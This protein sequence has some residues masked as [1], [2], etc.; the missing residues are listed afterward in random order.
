MDH[1]HTAAAR[2]GKGPLGGSK[3]AR[4]R[5]YLILLDN[6]ELVRT[7]VGD[8]MDGWMDGLIGTGWDRMGSG[9]GMWVEIERA[10]LLLST[11]I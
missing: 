1:T 6:P 10:Q 5:P 9:R 4:L 8:L 11:Q 7:L 3:P 2:A